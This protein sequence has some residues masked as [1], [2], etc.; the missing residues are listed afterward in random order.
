MISVSEKTQRNF[1]I[2]MKDGELWIRCGNSFFMGPGGSGKTCTLS[3]ILKEDPPSIRDSTSCV[4]KP[5]RAVAQCK[6]G[7]SDKT[8]SKTC[9]VRITDEQYSDMLST[10]AKHLYTPRSHGPPTTEAIKLSSELRLSQATLK[11]T[12]TSTEASSQSHSSS[13]FDS[14]ATKQGGFRRELLVRMNA[15]S[16]AADKLQNKDMFNISDS[17]GQPMFHEVL[18][19]FVTNTMIGMLTVKLN[20]SLDSHPLVEY[21]INGEPIGEPFKAPFTHLQTFCH[22]MRVLQSTCEHGTCPKIV[23]IGT[24]KDLEHE[25][26]HENRKEKDRKLLSIIPPCLLYTSPSPRDATLSRMPSS[27]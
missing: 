6:V 20:E 1:D 22:C 7:V 14:Q 17:G 25:C 9:F 13:K 21:Y 12:S 18:P 11:H 4:K 8:A 3:A 27:A 5:V 16:K 19:V 26:Q 10:T 23:F 24:H 15:G 2:A